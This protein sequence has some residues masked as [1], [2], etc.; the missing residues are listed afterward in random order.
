MR[1][2]PFYQTSKKLKARG[3]LHTKGE[4]TADLTQ[5]AKNICLRMIRLSSSAFA[6][7]NEVREDRALA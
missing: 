3:Q 1:D 2:L 6:G 7:G 5:P 4:S